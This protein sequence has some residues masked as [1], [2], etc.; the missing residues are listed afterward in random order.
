MRSTIEFGIFLQKMRK[1]RKLTLQSA[2][3]YIGIDVS[4]LSKIEHGERQ[5]QSHM[6]APLAELFQIDY[7]SF[8]IEYIQ[9]RI[10]Q[11]FGQ[12]PFVEEAVSKFL[13]ER[14]K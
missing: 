1:E 14:K 13:R 10:N 3:K 7:K 4:M 6:I 12:E 2:A 5:L 8:Q 11:E 9:Q